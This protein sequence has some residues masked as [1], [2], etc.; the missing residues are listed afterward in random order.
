MQLLPGSWFLLIG[1][2]LSPGQKVWTLSSPG[3][4]AASVMPRAA[5]ERDYPRGELSNLLQEDGGA[6]RRR[7]GLREA[8]ANVANNPKHQT[9][10]EEQR[11]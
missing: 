1:P 10:S 5:R 11:E 8:A 9:R 2:S 6:R 4:M 3:H 7:H